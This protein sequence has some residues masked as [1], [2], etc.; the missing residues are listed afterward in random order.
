MRPPARCGRA[1]WFFPVRVAALLC[2]LFFMAG[3]Q[4]FFQDHSRQALDAA[5][6]KYL[7]GDYSGAVQYYE[8]AI[9]GTPATADVHYK[10][11]LLFDDKLQNPLAAVYHFQRYL[12]LSPNGA[13]AKDAANFMK[14]DQLKLVT[15][16]SHGAFMSQEDAVRLKN[17]NLILRQQLTELRASRAP[18]PKDN[19]PQNPGATTSA[20]LPPP[21]GSRTYEV[22]AGDTLASISR[23]FFKNSGRWKDIQEANYKQLK[24]TSK[25]KPG[26]TLVIPK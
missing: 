25:L 13:H 7:E 6:K 23:K 11:A 22:Q 17:D 3:C 8:D 14:E 1:E 5:D 16:F 24:G 4:R 9:D 2:A 21:A 15:N 10:L 26:M 20:D 12:E 19:G 18:A